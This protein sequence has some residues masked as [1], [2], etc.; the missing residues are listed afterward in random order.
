MHSDEDETDFD[1]DTVYTGNC[2]DVLQEMPAESVHA[3]V[4]DPPYGLN[5]MPSVTKG[6]DD[7]EPREYQRWCTEWA[8]EARRVVKPGGHMLAF[9][10]T[11]TFHRLATG[12]EDAG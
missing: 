6:W 7:F 2:I 4:T 3:V 9:S 11:R 10:G 1:T 12:V 8:R 5:F